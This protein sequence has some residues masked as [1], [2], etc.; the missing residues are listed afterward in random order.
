MISY[1]CSFSLA[2]FSSTFFKAESVSTGLAAP[3]GFDLGL[4]SSTA[5][6]GVD[7]GSCGCSLRGNKVNFLRCII[8]EPP[9]EGDDGGGESIS[10]VS[11]KIRNG[12]I[13]PS[14]LTT[15]ANGLADLHSPVS[16]GL[17]RGGERLGG[18][19]KLPLPEREP[20]PPVRDRRSEDSG[21]GRGPLRSHLS[22][23]LSLDARAISRRS[24]RPESLEKFLVM[25]GSL[26]PS[27][28]RDSSGGKTFPLRHS[29]WEASSTP[30][31]PDFAVYVRD[32]LYLVGGY[33]VLRRSLLQRVPPI[34]H[35]RD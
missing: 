2:S 23:P 34:G 9:K 7:G 17:S 32:P 11:I 5:E 28:F 12:H 22:V 19:L 13:L 20:N 14:D 24:G 25:R 15:G 33:V 30:N 26:S 3:K 10:K 16:A 29:P 21:G 4:I 18:P 35:L 27:L 6:T 8:G 31:P 1:L